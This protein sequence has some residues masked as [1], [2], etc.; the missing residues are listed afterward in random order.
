MCLH[1]LFHNRF[2]SEEDDFPP[3]LYHMR[4]FI[5]SYAEEGEAS[6]YISQ[7]ILNH[8]KNSHLFDPSVIKQLLF[9][10]VGIPV[11]VNQ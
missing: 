5:S 6:I 10:D 4:D 8:L 3:P 1:A 9:L 11:W 2:N 7:F